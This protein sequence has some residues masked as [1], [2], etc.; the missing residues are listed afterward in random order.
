MAIKFEDATAPKGKPTEKRLE[1]ARAVVMQD[2]A[3]SEASSE[4]FSEA[5]TEKPAAPKKKIAV[6]AKPAKA[7]R[8]S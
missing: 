8:K 6:R 4:A 5:P 2:E 3:S 7:A 1:K